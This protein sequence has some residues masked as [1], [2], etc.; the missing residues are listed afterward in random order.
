[1]RNEMDL[2]IWKRISGFVAVK[3]YPKLPCPYCKERELKINMESIQ[4]RHIS[5]DVLIAASR[6][7]RGEKSYRY[8]KAKSVQSNEA[9]KRDS[10]CLF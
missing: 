6:K 8:W 3:S 4:T 10:G 1:M 7:Y 9:T 2:I 5:E